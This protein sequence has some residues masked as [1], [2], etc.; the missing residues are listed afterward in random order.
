MPIRRLSSAWLPLFGA[1][2]LLCVNQWLLHGAR[3]LGA[4]VYG[5]VVS[6]YLYCVFARRD[7]PGL[8]W[9]MSGATGL[10]L[11]AINGLVALPDFGLAHA[12]ETPAHPEHCPTLQLTLFPCSDAPTF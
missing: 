2:A 4:L 6:A 11:M 8:S 7:A 9:H 5:Y 10:L 1:L 3:P 12:T